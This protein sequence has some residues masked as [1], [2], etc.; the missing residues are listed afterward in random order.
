MKML[1]CRNKFTGGTDLRRIAVVLIFVGLLCGC[2]RATTADQPLPQP[3]GF[4]QKPAVPTSHLTKL[5][6]FL[7]LNFVKSDGVKTSLGKPAKSAKAAS[8]AEYLAESS[9]LWL[10]HL[11]N[12][13][14]YAQFRQFYRRTKAT[15]YNGKTFSYR[16]DPVTHKRSAV[17][18]SVDDLRLM[19][20]LIAYDQATHSKHYQAE[21]QVV[22]KAWAKVCLP[23]LQLRDLYDTH[24]RTA[25]TQGSLAFFDLQVLRYLGGHKAYQQAYRVVQ[26]GY[27][28]DALPV[29]AASYDWNGQTYSNK[30]LNTSEALE[31]LLQLARVGHLKPQSRAWLVSAV[32]RGYL[33]NAFTT[34]GIITDSNQSVGNWALIAQIFAV[35]HDGKHYDQTMALIWRQQLKAGPLAGGFGDQKT[36][37]SYSYNNLNVLLAGEVKQEAHATNQT[38]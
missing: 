17:N 21:L 24:S 4:A 23:Q 27:L 31:V 6:D 5:T 22:Y 36:G 8:G 19:R 15:L 10:L 18:A 26:G 12:T 13:G 32:S 3:T 30:D 37:I 29:Y 33:A 35:L 9:G 25:A 2:A 1:S 14:Q 16:Y 7:K 34:T 28:G 38:N 11:V 20:A